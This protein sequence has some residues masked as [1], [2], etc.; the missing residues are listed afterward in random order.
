MTVRIED[1]RTR[2]VETG[3]TVPQL[4]H[5]AEV[6]ML[7]LGVGL[8]AVVA[9]GAVGALLSGVQLAQWSIVVL[10]G[11][12]LPVLSLVYIRWMYWTQIAN[13]VEVTDEQFPDLWAIYAD[14]ARQMGFGA[15]PGRMAQVPRLYMVNGNGTMNAFAAKCQL[16]RGY[17]VVY[18]DLADLAYVHGNA[19]ALR[20]VLAHELGHIKCGH[21]N[22]WRQGI[23]PVLTLLR[24]A[25]SLSRA[26][27]YTADRVGAYYAPQHAMD[28]VALFAG[29]NVARQVDVPAYLRS[30]D[31][32]KDGFWLSF[33]N[34]MSGHAVGFRRMKALSRVPTEGWDVHGRML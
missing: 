6:P 7:A 24:L 25:P 26:Q 8:T 14:L 11:L 13:G 16:Q 17:V 1:D 32:H 29:K 22:L 5:R 12:A 33:A 34:L 10:G 19:G 18:S 28:M 21:V 20:F 4:R 30:V 31:R 9:I 2:A 15:G 3:P 27:E 23:T